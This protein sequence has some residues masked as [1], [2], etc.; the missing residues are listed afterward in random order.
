VKFKKGKIEFLVTCTWNSEHE[1]LAYLQGGVFDDL[2]ELGC[3]DVFLDDLYSLVGWDIVMICDD[4]GSMSQ[5][6]DHGTRWSELKDNLNRLL[7]LCMVLDSDGIDIYFLN[8]PGKTNITKASSVE[9][10]FQSPPSGGTGLTEALEKVLRTKGEAP[11]IIVIAT[12]GAPNSIDSFTRA[13]K[14][15]PADVYVSFLACTDNAS[16]VAY[17]NQVLTMLLI[18]RI[19]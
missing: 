2:R 5:R 19:S 10:L 12:D 14:R 6:T 11:M 15:K 4:S 16:D 18:L 7:K 8:R 13:L 17:L 9:R 1:R 3:H